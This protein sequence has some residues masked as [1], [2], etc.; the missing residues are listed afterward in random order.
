[1]AFAGV[2]NGRDTGC[3]GN[4]KGCGLSEVWVEMDSTVNHLSLDVWYIR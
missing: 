4:T 1:M 2:D 3:D